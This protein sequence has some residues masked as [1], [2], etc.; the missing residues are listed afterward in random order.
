MDYRAIV[1]LSP[2]DRCENRRS[3]E[4]HRSGSSQVIHSDLA[5]RT[6]GGKRIPGVQIRIVEQKKPAT[7]KFVCAGFSEYF[8]AAKAYLIVFGREW[9]LV[10]EDL[11]NSLFCRQSLACREAINI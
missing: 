8:D 10:D 5:G 9:I 1:H 4:Y 11:S 3:P 6:I 7:V 2:Q